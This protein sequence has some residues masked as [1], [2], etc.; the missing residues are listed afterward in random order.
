MIFREQVNRSRTSS[1]VMPP[2]LATCPS[3]SGQRGRAQQEP[4][5]PCAPGHD[6]AQGLGFLGLLARAGAATRSSRPAT[7][8]L[9]RGHHLSVATGC[10]QPTLGYQPPSGEELAGADA[11]PGGDQRYANARQV[12]LLEDPDLAFRSPSPPAMNP[13]EDLIVAVTSGRGYDLARGR[14]RDAVRLGGSRRGLRRGRHRAGPA[15][16]REGCMLDVRAIIASGRGATSRWSRALRLGSRRTSMLLP[17]APV[18]GPGHQ[19]QALSQMRLSGARRSRSQRIRYR[20]WRGQRL[21]VL[22]RYQP[23]GMTPCPGG[24]SKSRVLPRRR[25]RD[26]PSHLR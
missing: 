7:P 18:D 6:F 10:G 12:R 19:G 16:C 25:R 23:S 11:V 15:A 21:E 5:W 9:G 24:Q 20:G 1:A 2:A 8:V 26:L 3:P 4:F 17:A 14:G 22:A 13:G